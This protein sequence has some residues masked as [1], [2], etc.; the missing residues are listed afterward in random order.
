MSFDSCWSKFRIDQHN[1]ITT[2]VITE[3]LAKMAF[4]QGYEAAY[5]EI[6]NFAEKLEVTEIVE[7]LKKKVINK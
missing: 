3:D 2:L 5:Q 1:N 6:R 4:Q 7:L